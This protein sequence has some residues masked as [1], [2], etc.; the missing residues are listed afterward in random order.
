MLNSQELNRNKG[1]AILVIISCFFMVH[2]AYSKPLEIWVNSFTDQKYYKNMISLY[3]KKVD[4]KFTANVKSFGFME[5]PDKLAVA[6]KSGINTPDIVQMDEMFFSMYLAHEVPFLDLTS[7]I[8][9]AKLDQNILPQRMG[10]FAYKGKTY[11]LPQSVF[12]SNVVLSQ[13]FI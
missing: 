3:Q 4:K 9:K 8:K 7:R 1:L 5:M 13:R 12:G 6:I 11:G 2:T 10:L